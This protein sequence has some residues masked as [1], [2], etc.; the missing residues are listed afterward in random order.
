MQDFVAACVLEELQRVAASRLQTNHRSSPGASRSGIG[1]LRNPC[2][3]VAM[4][5]PRRAK[6]GAEPP[7]LRMRSA[8]AHND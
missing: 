5:S 8:L 3:A 7:S 1:F 4:L 2:Q 6:H